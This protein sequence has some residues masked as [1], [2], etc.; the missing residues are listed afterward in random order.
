[1]STTAS[2]LLSVAGSGM[3]L[4]LA[5]QAFRFWITRDWPRVCTTLVAVLVVMAM[6]WRPTLPFELA[7]KLRTPL[8]EDLL[9]EGPG[10]Q[11]H[12]PTSADGPGTTPSRWAA[13]RRSRP[14]RGGSG[15]AP[16]P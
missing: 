3:C 6:V 7:A 4:F 14:C 2:W 12:D 10:P 1:M 8:R 11:H 16:A 9:D 5:V 15:S 13:V